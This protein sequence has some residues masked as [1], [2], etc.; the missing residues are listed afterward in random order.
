VSKR[1]YGRRGSAEFGALLKQW[2]KAVRLTQA[3]A[4]E[5]LGIKS[6][7]PGAYLS[8]IEKGERPIPDAV[9]ANV[10]NVYSKRAEE[11]IKAAYHPQ[12]PMPLLALTLD[13][14][15]LP[16]SIEDYLTELGDEEKR[17]L[18]KYAAFL[19][20]RHKTE[21]NDIKVST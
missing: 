8:L 17:D 11:V 2:R 10:P 15:S 14:S 12:I 19:V 21:Q 20:L 3:Q 7:S 5:R 16:K 4:A 9:L 13:P 18:I 6:A 1:R